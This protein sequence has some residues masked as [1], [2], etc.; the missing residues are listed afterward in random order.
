MSLEPLFPCPI[1]MH[2]YKSVRSI[3]Q[4]EQHDFSFRFQTLAFNQSLSTSFSWPVETDVST[5]CLLNF[6]FLLLFLDPFEAIR[7]TLILSPW[8]LFSFL[9]H[10]FSRSESSDTPG[11]QRM[12]VTLGWLQPTMQ[13]RQV[14]VNDACMWTIYVPL[15][16]S[17]T[18]SS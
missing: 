9:K 3:H 13:E 11:F 17:Y 16:L 5:P 4:C 6:A 2:L 10:N 14:P 15:P 1:L 8:I 18:M 12:A 7:F